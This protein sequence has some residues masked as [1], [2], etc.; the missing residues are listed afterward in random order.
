MQAKN[1]YLKECCKLGIIKMNLILQMMNY[2]NDERY[3]YNL[4]III[5]TVKFSPMML[6]E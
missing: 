2:G 4:A 6:C 3:A 1:R 5:R